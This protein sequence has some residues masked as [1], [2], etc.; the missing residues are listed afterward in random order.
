[1]R[2]TFHGPLAEI[3]LNPFEQQR[4]SL[5]VGVGGFGVS[6]ISPQGAITSQASARHGYVLGATEGEHLVHFRDHGNIYIRGGV[7]TG[8]T[9]FA[10]GTQQ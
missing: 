10:M 3:E 6:Q 1:M 2:D 4:R 5:L 9:D 8:S 7:A